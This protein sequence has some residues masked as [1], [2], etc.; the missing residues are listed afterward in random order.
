MLITSAGS[1]VGQN[2]LD[3]LESKRDAIDVIGMNA[4]AGNPRNFRYDR[5]Y[6]VAPL[7]DGSRFEAEFLEIVEKEDPDMI[8]AGR[9]HDVVFLAEIKERVPKL[10]SKIPF[11]DASLAAMMQDKWA[12][13]RYAAKNNLPFADSYCYGGRKDTGGLGAFLERHPLPLLIKPR[14]GYGSLGV[15]YL[16]KSEQIDALLVQDS[17][18][19]ILFQEYLGPARDFDSLA[20]LLEHGVPLFFQIPETGQYAAQTVIAPSGTIADVFV[21]INTMVSGRAEYSRC[22]DSP[23]IEA[24]VRQYAR[25]L[26]RD[27]WYGPLNLQLKQDRHGVWKVFELNPRMTG[28]TS[29]RYLL[30]YD[31][32][33][34]L[35]DFF[36]PALNL[37]NHT[38]IPKQEGAVFKYLTDYYLADNDVDVLKGSGAWEKS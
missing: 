37:P 21:S 27:G 9:D 13:F 4:D 29:A 20:E 31:E 28:T 3:C 26:S 36:L 1:L 32:I 11:G 24:V 2:L 7:D 16:W 35:T 22:I 15:R 10:H 18:G 12:S 25:A 30:G 33:G 19:E 14:L 17:G 6:L 8:L 23:D 5:A 38:K 34:F